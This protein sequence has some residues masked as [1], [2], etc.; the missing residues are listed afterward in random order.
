M[1]YRWPKY[2]SKA[3]F[4]LAFEF[5]FDSFSPMD[6]FSLSAV[7][8]CLMDCT[9]AIFAVGCADRSLYND[10]VGSHSTIEIFDHFRLFA[11]GLS[12]SSYE[13]K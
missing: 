7:A 4:V 2:F 13:I 5:L 12:E 1:I 3:K 8:G 6:R 10:F 9:C 11:G